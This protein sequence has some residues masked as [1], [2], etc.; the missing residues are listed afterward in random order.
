[1]IHD[2][3]PIRDCQEE[4]MKTE[5]FYSVMIWVFVLNACA[6]AMADG[7]MMEKVTEVMM[8]KPTEAMAMHE[9]PT[10]ADRMDKPA[11]GAMMDAPAWSIRCRS[12]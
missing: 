5:S 6:P 1:M 4:P 8:E 10:P 2:S 3:N 7:A 11:E 12:G 9:T